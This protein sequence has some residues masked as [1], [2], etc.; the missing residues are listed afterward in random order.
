VKFDDGSTVT[1][2]FIYDATAGTVVDFDLH[3]EGFPSGDANQHFPC[4]PDDVVLLS[5]F[6]TRTCW[7]AQGLI[8][9]RGHPAL[10]HHLAPHL[11][12]VPEKPLTNEG[13]I[14][15]LS[16]G[17]LH[18]FVVESGSAKGTRDGSTLVALVAG[19]L[20]G[21]VVP[22]SSQALF[23]AAGLILLLGLRARQK[24]S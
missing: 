24:S 3:F 20:V 13:G 11:K 14:V 9:G 2:S 7:V 6:V 18:G 15:H 8:F 4:Q 5:D 19:N 16:P 12:L 21:T 17:V 23:L 10:S 1:G 22:E